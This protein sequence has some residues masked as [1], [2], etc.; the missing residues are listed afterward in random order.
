MK[1]TDIREASIN[2]TTNET[3]ISLYINLDKSGKSKIST[4]CHFFNHMLELFAKHSKIYVELDAKGDTHIDY[5][6]LVEDIGI[7]FG[8]ALNEA[9][10]DKRGIQRYANVSLPMD[11]ALL[12]VALDI[13]GR[14]YL[15]YNTDSVSSIYHGTIKEFDV[16]LVSEFLY[17]FAINAKIT[18]HVNVA[19]GQNKHHIVEGI[20]KALAI[21]LRDALKIVSDEIP[22]TKGSLNV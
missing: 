12:N 13:S 10:G 14:G 9:L 19:Y 4:P 3:D 16:E 18:L 2:R 17:A 20:F 11:E 6:H 15:V 21:S 7:A 5:H 8:N 22:S 1:S